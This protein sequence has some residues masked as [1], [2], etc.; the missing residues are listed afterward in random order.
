MLVTV[1]CLRART[2]G[3]CTDAA[4]CVDAEPLWHS[5]SAG[6][7]VL[8]SDP[9][10]PRWGQLGASATLGF[11]LKP[12]VL[13]AP[14]PNAAGREI[15]LIS[16]ATDLS[17]GAR[18]GI[19]RG[20]EVTLALPAGLYQRGAGIKGVTHQSAPESPPQ[21]LHDPRI[22]FG[23][24]LLRSRSTGLGAKLRYELKLPLGDEMALS[25]EQSLVSSPALIGYGRVGRLF[26]GLELAA[27][28]RPAVSFFGSRI[29]SQA[30]LA[31]GV[32]YELPNPQLAMTL[33]A[34]ALP[35]LIGG[36][37][38]RHLPAEWHMTA[39]YTPARAGRFSFGFG[40]GTALPSSHDAR[41]YT[42]LGAPLFRAVAF[43]RF[44]PMR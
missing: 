32:G 35:S 5:P 2:A 25:G 13:I 15:N 24:E 17:L 33:E 19:G 43:A 22:G 11:R 37:S 21:T 14:A 42:S 16:H 27:R 29:G 20:M 10:S 3:A 26:A 28:L 1:L 8:V 4:P 23:F 31:V 38:T 34:Y 30:L 9:T 39:R 44:A 40:A 7:F 18:L 41:A 12:A 36:G 6:A